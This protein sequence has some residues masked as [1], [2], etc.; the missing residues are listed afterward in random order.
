M[1][2]VL[3]LTAL[4]VGAAYADIVPN[5]AV[6]PG[7]VTCEF[8]IGLGTNVCTYQYTATLHSQ[9]K[10]TGAKDEADYFTIYDFNGY[11][12]GT[13]VAPVD[14]MAS[15]DFSGLTPSLILIGDKDDPDVPNL[16][17]TYVGG[18]DI[19]DGRTITG[20][21]AKSIFG[22]A[23]ITDW[24]SSQAHKQ[25][26]TPNGVVQNVGPVQVPQLPQNEPGDVPE[27]M[28]M[29]L[30]GGGLAALGLLPRR[31]RK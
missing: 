23:T 9:T 17:F 27:P 12:D 19:T 22:P 15:S 11:L 31:F 6:G 7:A 16:T 28:S 21:S 25:G 8:D 1:K 5:L 20:F 4:A 29:A 14:W 26:D 24:Y 2:K 3:F 18:S 30:L 10:V 13:A